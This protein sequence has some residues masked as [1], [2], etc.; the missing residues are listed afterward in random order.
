MVHY[1]N[2]AWIWCIFDVIVLSFNT[3]S[4]SRGLY[5]VVCNDS[6]YYSGNGGFQEISRIVAALRLPIKYNKPVIVNGA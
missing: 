4:V 6:G 2:N 5:H 1:N 3:W